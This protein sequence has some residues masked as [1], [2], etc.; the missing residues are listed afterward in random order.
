MSEIRRVKVPDD[1]A[2]Q[3]DDLSQDRIN[4]LVSDALRSALGVA[5]SAEEKREELHARRRGNGR[6]TEELADDDSTDDMTD[7]EK[8]QAELR[9]R[10]TE[11]R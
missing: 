7:V 11:G 6:S 4:T 8:R 3:L 5:E 9:E 2:E 1:V 10:I